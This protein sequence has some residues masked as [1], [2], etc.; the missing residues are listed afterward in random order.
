LHHCFKH[1]FVYKIV[2]KE[3]EISIFIKIDTKKIEIFEKK[4]KKIDIDSGISQVDRELK[5]DHFA[6]FPVV[7]SHLNRKLSPKNEKMGKL[8]G[9]VS[10]LKP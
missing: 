2:K 7:L 4:K 5:D 8:W 10:P 3:R 9:C 1:C 6:F